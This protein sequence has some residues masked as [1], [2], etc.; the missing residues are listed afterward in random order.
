MGK[1]ANNEKAS[2]KA[3][4]AV[5]GL[6]IREQPSGRTL[7]YAVYRRPVRDEV[8][9]KLKSK[10]T[11]TTLGRG[12][13]MSRSEARNAAKRALGAARL[14][15]SKGLTG[16]R[17]KDYVTRELLNLDRSVEEIEAAAAKQD[18]CPTVD[19]FIDE[20]YGPWLAAKQK[21]AKNGREIARLKYILKLFEPGLN[22]L[23]MKV[24]KVG[25]EQIEDWLTKRR[26]TVSART[27]KIPASMTIQRDLVA[28]SGLFA[29]AIRPRKIISLNPVAEVEHKAVKNEIVRFLGSNEEDKKEEERLLKALERREK[30]K[31]EKRVAYN[32]W[33]KER[34]YELRPEYPEDQ[35]TDHLRPM[36][37]LAMNT[38]MRRGQLFSLRW[39]H[40][41]FRKGKSGENN[42]TIRVPGQI[43]KNNK[44]H[45]LPLN[46]YAT[47]VLR[48]WHNQSTG[49]FNK[50][51]FVFPGKKGKRLYDIRR[52]WKSVLR[53][54][55]IK[56]FEFRHLRHHF[57]SQLVMNGEPLNSVREL[58]TH[59]DLQM[60]LR[61]AH[62]APDHKRD[63][64]QT[65]ATD[66]KKWTI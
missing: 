8:T 45:V 32:Q 65:L 18:N 50:N 53:D 66:K 25:S 14:A 19:K 44:P 51:A 20:K 43:T 24:N 9:G 7:Y 17:V 36:V 41:E 63:S 39:K 28:I 40:V 54:A 5:K 15:V 34:G 23:S 64:V 3:D 13:H 16:D 49:K 59:R 46:D 37:L 26:S 33:A 21:Y 57:A 30:R 10:T 31:R 22:L 2:E 12:E 47:A 61:Y 52:A 56:D 1:R 27:G 55:K 60:T 4:S 35:Y 42:S 11:R 62:L 6:R 29:H 38:G 58:M 48:K